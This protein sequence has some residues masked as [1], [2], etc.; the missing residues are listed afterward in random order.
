MTKHI[1]VINWK[2]GCGKT[3]IATHL[4]VAL[5][6]SGLETGLADYD[7]Q[8][9][10]KLWKKLRP[11]EAVAVEHGERNGRHRELPAVSQDQA[12]A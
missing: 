2:G 7:R 3:T 5:A 12:G 11:N 9:T 6:A 10:A 8:K 1:C 4:A